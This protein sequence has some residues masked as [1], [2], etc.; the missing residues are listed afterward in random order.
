MKNYDH[1][2]KAACRYFQNA[3]GPGSLKAVEPDK[4]NAV[5]D[6]CYEAYCDFNK[7]TSFKMCDNYGLESNKRKATYKKDEQD[8]ITSV[9]F[10]C[11]V[12]VIMCLIFA[13][14]FKTV[15]YKESQ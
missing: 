10:A 3:T 13:A 1:L 15:T 11:I 7:D 4:Y 12:L 2:S 14:L 9:V 5:M 6:L 8:I